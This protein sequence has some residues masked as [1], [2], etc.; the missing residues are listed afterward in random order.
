MAEQAQ[1]RSVQ[2]IWSDRRPAYAGDLEA[3][4][5]QV[6][7]GPGNYWVDAYHHIGR[8]ILTDAPKQLVIEAMMNTMLDHMSDQQRNDGTLM[9][10]MQEMHDELQRDLS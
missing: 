6:E 5:Y 10:T 1:M 9:E 7:L 4:G 8:E 3:A 2:L